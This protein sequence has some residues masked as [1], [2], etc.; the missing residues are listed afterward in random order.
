MIEIPGVEIATANCGIRYKNRDD[1]L[2]AKFVNGTVVAG[3]FTKS[4]TC[5]A[6]VIWCKKNIKGGLARGLIVNAGNANAFTGKEGEKAVLRVTKKVAEIFG[7]KQKE[8]FMSSTGVI[9]ERLKDELIIDALP[10][11]NQKL[12]STSIN[13]QSAA[14]AILTTDTSKKFC[15]RVVKIANVPI[16][17]TGFVKG[18]GMVAP[19]MATMLGYIFTDANI[20]AEVL[21]QLLS[22]LNQETFNAIT[23]DS[24]TSTNDT[25]LMFATKK[26][27]NKEIGNINDKD[28]S[29]FKNVLRE[30]MLDLAKKIVVDGE[31]AT[32]LIEISVVGATSKKAAKV[33][34]LAIANSP[35]V[36]T[37]IAG[38][39]PNWGRIVMAIGKSGQK[40]NQ[41]KIGIKIGD[42]VIVKNGERSLSYLE[43]NVH[44]Y[45]KGREIKIEVDI[46]LGL[47]SKKL[48]N[49]AVVWTCDLTEAYI[50][51]NKDYRS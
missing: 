12:A 44:E 40:V 32:K 19:N 38:S 31:G 18:S 5:A 26:A 22:D 15:S 29:D 41:K 37:A 10:E 51:I 1:L 46:N 48:L 42:F 3:V 17:I 49:H 21:Q 9:G 25:V 33:I 45:M 2:L 30:L 6:P 11:L 27:N 8:V 14:S 47:S 16:K 39:D 23:V 35:L 28:L 13:W 20:K 34:A 7:C 24:D 43:K 4:S 50:R 36:K